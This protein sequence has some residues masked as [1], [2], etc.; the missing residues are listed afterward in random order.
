MNIFA[1]A[2]PLLLAQSSNNEDKQSTMTTVSPSDVSKAVTDGVQHDL[3][4]ELL[5]VGLGTTLIIIVV[6]SFR[7]W[8]IGRH[9]DPSP[10]ALFSAIARK[11]GLGW[12]DR[13]LLWRISKTFDLPTPITLML[14]RGALR[15]YTDLYLSNRTSGSRRTGQRIAQIE[16][17]LFG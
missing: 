13:Y 6:I 9:N 4:W 15:H 8:W 2:A 1:N 7:R 5:L 14:S 12:R 16:S 11:A 10:F 17:M 3:P